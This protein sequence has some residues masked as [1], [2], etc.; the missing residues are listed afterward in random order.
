M[1]SYPPFFPKGKDN[2]IKEEGIDNTS[3]TLEEN[4]NINAD[5]PTSYN[6]CKNDSI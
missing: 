2:T 4:A 1:W 3:M 6:A 5:H